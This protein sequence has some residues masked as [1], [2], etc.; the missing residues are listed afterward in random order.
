M[1]PQ[2]A[3]LFALAAESF[4]NVRPW[5]YYRYDDDGPHLIDGD[6][7]S[8]GD[9]GDDGG[10]GGGGGRRRDAALGGA[11]L[12][13]DAARAEALL[14]RALEIDG[15]HPLALHLHIHV[16]EAG[17]PTLEGDGGGD[18]GRG[19]AAA[20]RW[21]GRALG[22]ADALAALRPEQGHLL[23]MPSHIYVR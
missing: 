17:T 15:R 12:R 20:A 10:G 19:G 11:A 1:Q 9:A 5:D 14:L 2:D 8:D 18:G 7:D 4:M 3:D 13:P 6:G 22:S 16:A 23:H 21:A